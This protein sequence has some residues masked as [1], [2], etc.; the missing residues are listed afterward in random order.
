ML[1]HHICLSVRRLDIARPSRITKIRNGPLFNAALKLRFEDS[2]DSLG[3][4]GKQ[5]DFLGCSNA[6]KRVR[7]P[8]LVQ[9][10]FRIVI[11]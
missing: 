5:F 8:S 9:G 1:G 4:C 2:K 7:N 3:I 11:S 10:F 6:E